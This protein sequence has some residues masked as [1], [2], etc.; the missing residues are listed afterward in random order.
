MP[1]CA[2]TISSW[3]RKDLH[4]AK[5]HMSTGALQG[6]A[7]STGLVADVSQVSILHVAGWARVSTPASQYFFTYITSKNWHKDLLQ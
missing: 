7:A 3:V 5:I 2:K 6:A 4:I 1:V